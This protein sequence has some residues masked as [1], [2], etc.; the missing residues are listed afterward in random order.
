MAETQRRTHMAWNRTP[1]TILRMPKPSSESE[2]TN[3]R[4]A[5]LVRERVL[6][7]EARTELSEGQL[8]NDAE[9]EAWLNKLDIDEPSPLTPLN[10]ARPN[11]R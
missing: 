8:L 5:R 11:G 4:A 7:E 6:I 1:M 10:S 3:E 9:F 2:T